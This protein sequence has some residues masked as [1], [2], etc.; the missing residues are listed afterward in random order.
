VTPLPPLFEDFKNEGI[1][2]GR[3]EGRADGIEAVLDLRFGA[4]GVELMPRVRKITD[5]AVLERL[6][7]E[8]KS[9][10]DVAAFAALLPP[11]A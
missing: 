3:A 6:L 1:A 10:P 8:A 2:E 5:A 7:R 9:V 11:Q 4:P